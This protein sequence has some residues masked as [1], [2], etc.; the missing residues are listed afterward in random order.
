VYKSEVLFLEGIHP[1]VRVSELDDDRLRSILRRARTLLR[2]NLGPGPR[3]T[4][5][6]LRGPR[7]WVYERGDRPCLR[8]GDAIVRFV[9]GPPPGRSTYFCASC[10]PRRDMA[11]EARPA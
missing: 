8:C 6:A 9:Q 10:Q 5:R 7:L 1:C 4:R 11:T 3:T 2:A